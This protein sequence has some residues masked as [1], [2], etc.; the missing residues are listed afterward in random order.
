MFCINGKVDANTTMHTANADALS[1]QQKGQLKHHNA[2]AVSSYCMMHET[3]DRERWQASTE[4][5]P[6]TSILNQAHKP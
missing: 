4:E 2:I 6:H 5:N 3:V 1:I